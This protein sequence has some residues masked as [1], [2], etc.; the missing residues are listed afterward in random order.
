M[1]VHAQ[2]TAQVLRCAEGRG[3]V[4]AAMAI[5]RRRRGAHFYSKWRVASAARL[6]REVLSI[7][8]VSS[9]EFF[10]ILGLIEG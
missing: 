4:A 2:E 1:P 9:T 10:A 3:V 5:A 6:A 7:V 8:E